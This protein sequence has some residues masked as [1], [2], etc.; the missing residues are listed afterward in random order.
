MGREKAGVFRQTYENYLKEISKK[1]F[2]RI[3]LIIGAIKDGKDLVLP[4]LK[5]AY[6]V[7]PDGVTDCRGKTVPFSV[8]VVLLKY[9]LMA[10]ATRPTFRG[11]WMNFRDFSDARPLVSYFA[12]NVTGVLEKG[13]A[14]RLDLLRQR[15]MALGG[16]ESVFAASFDL[17]MTIPVLPNV[18]VVL[19][20]N[21]RDEA[22]PAVANLL[23]D[24]S[25]AL[26][27]DMECVGITGATLAGTIL[28]DR[29][30]GQG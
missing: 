1:D 5:Q 28:Q 4:Y 13:F 9:V 24:R 8:C 23:Y 14:G 3:S 11:E 26:C 27:L 15:C 6:R 2:D 22:F 25:V 10:P 18:T 20:F 7:S 12:S 16:E 30:P 29:V 21:D 17:S 19:N